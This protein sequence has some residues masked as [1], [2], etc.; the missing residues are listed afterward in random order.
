MPWAG[1]CGG[2]V[3][4]VQLVVQPP[5]ASGSHLVRNDGIGYRFDRRCVRRTASIKG[6]IG[7]YRL[8]QS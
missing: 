2:R 6:S 7:P 4:L 3:A 8:P 5:T 1:G